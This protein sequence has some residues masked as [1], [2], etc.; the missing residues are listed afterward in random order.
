MTKQAAPAARLCRKGINKMAKFTCPYCYGTHTLTDCGMKCSYNVPGTDIQ[1]KKN[2][3]KDDEGW[4]P[5]MYKRQCLACGDARKRIYCPTVDKEIPREFL[6][7]E[8]LP[9]ALVGAKASGKSNY[10]AVLI[11]EI[12]RKMSG[13]FNC[14]LSIS[15]DEDSKRFYDQFYKVPLFNRGEVVNA[16]DAGEIPPMIFPLRFMDKKNRIVRSATLTFYD[17]AGENLDSGDEMLIYN[18]YIPNSKGIILLLDP[19]Q[20]PAIRA[21]LEGKMPLPA[22]NTEV[23]D[24]LS[25]VVEN[26]RSVRNITG[27]INIPL[28]LAFTKLDALEKFDV[29]PEDSILRE[30]SRHLDM[31]VFSQSEF[32]TCNIEMRDILENWLDDELVQLMKNFSKYAFFGVSALGDVPTNNRLQ[33]IKPKRVLDPLLWLLAENKYIKKVK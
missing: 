12:R 27:T 15:C 13:S 20:V 29:L 33:E 19:L 10:I 18:R 14:S 1:C 11:N 30:N 32:E 21:Q 22:M 28:A 3:P 26:I 8:S 2:L 5:A 9:I 4:I 25:R 31:G 7:G 16:T 6:S 24:V 17:T 23:T